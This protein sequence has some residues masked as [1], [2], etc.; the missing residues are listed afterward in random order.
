[1][2]EPA[3][4]RTNQQEEQ[5]ALISS[6]RESESRFRALIQASSDVVYRMSADWTHLRQLA[7]QDFV[8]DATQGSSAWLQTYIPPAD[9]KQVMAVVERAIRSG[10]VFELEHR[11]LRVDG[12]IGWT[13]S[14]AI[15]VFDDAGRIIEW[16]GMA[17]DI[18]AR[19]QAEVALRESEDR[20]RRLFDS[21]DEGFCIIE[22][23]FDENQQ[24]VD[25]R[26]LEFNPAFVRQT[27]L[28]GAVG[29]R[30]RELLPQTEQHWFDTYARIVQTGEPERF[31][32][33]AAALGRWY[34]VYAFRL[35]PTESRRVAVL[36]NDVTARKQTE[37]ALV[38]ARQKA[39]EANRSKSR[40]LAAA[41][42]DLRQ[43]LAALT[44]YADAL[45]ARVLHVDRPLADSMKECLGTLSELL[46]DLLDLSKLDA[47]VVTPNWADLSIAELLQDIERAYGPEARIKGLNL[48]IVRSRTTVRS[49]AVLLRRIVGNF[50]S[51]AIRY[52]D[53]GRIVVGCRRR[54]DRLRI[55]VWDT[56]IGIPETQL[57]AI[58]EEFRQLDDSRQRGSGLG[59][60]IAAKTARLLDAPVRVR[61]VPSRGSVFSVEVQLSAAAPSRKRRKASVGLM[62]RVALLEDNDHVRKAMAVALSAQGHAVIPAATV[63]ELDAGLNGRAP[64]IL[65]ADY[66][67]TGNDNGID[68][69]ERLRG[70]F[71]P[72]LPAVL[73]TGDTDPYLL[74]SMADRGVIVLHKPVSIETLHSCITS[75]AERKAM[76]NEA[77]PQ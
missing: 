24:A 71:D 35:G 36:F 10:T 56:G 49:D 38:A 66:R 44:L 57:D 75:V 26:F 8:A 20:Y 63:Q 48:S 33:L 15:P 3:G 52:T 37:A 29:R 72:A 59:L 22:M 43:P 4:D 1:M 16:F 68:V 46:A 58:F 2:H 40:F 50:V 76:A 73:I 65:I 51:N 41:S 47:G 54:G 39:E 7:G 25:Y 74:R 23:I 19:K 11:V 77:A 5:K 6:L 70:R 42:H 31:E 32:N 34:D 53:K 12:S 28:N 18:T 21:I 64:D 13:F 62:L 55:E 9:Q 45:R 17:K 60:A 14:R 67:L 30:V 69:I 27:G 61:S